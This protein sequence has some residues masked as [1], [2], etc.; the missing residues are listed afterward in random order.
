MVLQL[1]LQGNLYKVEKAAPFG[2][3]KGNRSVLKIKEGIPQ[4][5]WPEHPGWT[6]EVIQRLSLRSFLDGLFSVHW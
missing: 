1:S 5:V 6:G 4:G 2:R 3:L